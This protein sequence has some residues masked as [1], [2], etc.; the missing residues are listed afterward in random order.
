MQ[1][2]MLIWNG[3]TDYIIVISYKYELTKS[4]AFSTRLHVILKLM[5]GFMA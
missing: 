5:V 4:V 3:T 2:Y 1:P